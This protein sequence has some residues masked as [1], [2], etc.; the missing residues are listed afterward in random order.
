[1]SSPRSSLKGKIIFSII[2]VLL[3]FIAGIL[4]SI[5][6]LVSI[7]LI[8]IF[9]WYELLEQLRINDLSYIDTFEFAIGWFIGIIVS[10]F[11]F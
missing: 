7:Q 9:L 1:M 11:S 4:N 10:Y 6:P 2:H 5:N 8:L 3:G